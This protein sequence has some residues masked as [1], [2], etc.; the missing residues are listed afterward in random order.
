MGYGM[1]MLVLLAGSEDV[2]LGSAFGN[3]TMRQVLLAGLPLPLRNSF[4]AD[5]NNTNPALRV[6]SFQ[7][8]YD[9]MFRTL[10]HYPSYPRTTTGNMN[11]SGANQSTDYRGTTPPSGA[12]RSYQMAWSIHHV[13]NGPARNAPNDAVPTSATP[14]FFQRES[15]MS[16]ATDGTMDMAYSLILAGEQ[17]GHGPQWHETHRFNKNPERRG[18][19]SYVFTYH[20]WARRMIN[21]IYHGHVN[22]NLHNNGWGTPGTNANATFNLKIHNV[23]ASNSA[24][25]RVTRPSD[26][27]MQ[28]LR[29]F[30]LIDTNA[31]DAVNG[32]VGRRNDWNR[33]INVTY[34][35]Q[36]FVREM[37]SFPGR[38]SA[39]PIPNTG[40]LPDFMRANAR[41]SIIPAN[42]TG[43]VWAV[44]TQQ[45]VPSCG[46]TT[47]GAC[48]CG[49]RMHETM[50]DGATHWN[51]CRVPWRLGAD[52]L[53][54]GT[55][56]RPNEDITTRAL[57][58]WHRAQSSN[59]MSAAR[60]RWLDGTLNGT[61][62]NGSNAFTGPMTVLSSVYGPQA[63][64]ESGWN[65]SNPNRANPGNAPSYNFYGDYINIL[66]MIASS[67]NE[68]TPVGRSLTVNGGTTANGFSHVRRVVPGARVPLR[69]PAAGFTR[70]ELNAGV[71]FWPGFT[72]TMNNTFIRMPADR[73]VTA[74][75]QGG[76]NSVTLQGG[77]TDSS[78]APA[79]PITAGVTVTV[80][81]GTRDGERFTGWTSTPIAVNFANANNGTT[82]FPMPSQ[83]VTVIANWEPDLPVDN[84][85]A[86]A[87]LYMFTMPVTNWA[88]GFNNADSPQLE[89]DVTQH[90]DVRLTVQWQNGD[91]T[92]VL[93]GTHRDIYLLLPTE[94]ASPDRL[95]VV[96]RSVRVNG[97]RVFGPMNTHAPAAGRWLVDSTVGTAN[98]VT[99][100][101]Q[102]ANHADNRAAA[103]NA[104]MELRT[105]YP[106]AN[107]FEI[108]PGATVD[109]IFRVGDGQPLWGD[110]DGNEVINSA[111]VTLLRRYLAA[112][113]K[114]DF[115]AAHQNFVRAN[116]DADGN[117]Y[118]T[119]D[120]LTWLRAHIGATNPATVPL[121]R[122]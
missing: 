114:I 106:A 66:T 104:G 48:T 34:D 6:V 38:T 109:F 41:S 26:F 4:T 11:S 118:I 98:P 115:Y 22:H 68:W 69:A 32:A 87:F 90:Q 75:V 84:N 58:D 39:N 47:T 62:G 43:N 89:F 70:W 33:V 57:S 30:S 15:G 110:V 74:S 12:R 5:I 117:N 25:G 7:T 113:S 93:H 50:F 9:A 67:G 99:F 40:I 107:A 24:A 101:A 20:E 44:P 10:R 76:G 2:N 29:A 82:T 3:R 63:W 37:T 23:G 86:T 55:N 54:I 21:D 92:G 72:A 77:G 94:E 120:D 27:M 56:A 16:S 17:W 1:L 49:R 79:N 85:M 60:G 64:F 42:G 112:V 103:E 96:L 52:L 45:D 71:E 28:H 88:F 65:T 13:W 31:G 116:A 59:N 122:R 100:V 46:A 105:F 78:V 36:R 83:S 119:Y 102:N 73:D 80:N 35:S 19:G 61:T 53:F 121:G 51:A 18:D 108:P 111:D 95:D 14:G 91:S 8:Y 81:A 97:E